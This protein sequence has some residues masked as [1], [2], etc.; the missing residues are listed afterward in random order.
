MVGIQDKPIMLS[1][2]IGKDGC[3]NTNKI[4]NHMVT[5]KHSQIVFQ[6]SSCREIRRRYVSQVGN[7]L[8]HSHPSVH[9]KFEH[10]TTTNYTNVS[11][12]VHICSR[13]SGLLRTRQ[14]TTS[15]ALYA[16]VCTDSRYKIL[17]VG[18][19]IRNRQSLEI[20]ST[21]V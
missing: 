9:N 14:L 18:R 2:P 20:V 12:C 4:S 15:H 8:S 11:V 6:S 16:L 1:H 13:M 17:V 3:R 21:E 5:H 10:Q 7:M 19:R